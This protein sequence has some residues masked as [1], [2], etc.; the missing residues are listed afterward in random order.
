MR[1]EKAQH[2]E[3]G[4]RRGSGDTATVL[5]DPELDASAR[6]RDHH[7]SP[8]SRPGRTRGRRTRNALIATGAAVAIGLTIAAYLLFWFRPTTT[9]DGARSTTI[10]SQGRATITPAKDWF[11]VG[12]HSD[13]VELLSPDRCLKVTL[14]PSPAG[15]PDPGGAGAS[16]PGEVRTEELASHLTIAHRD[17]ADRISAAVGDGRQGI[18]LEV[19]LDEK[20][21]QP[22]HR[23]LASY[24]PALAA[25]IETIRLS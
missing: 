17:S 18:Q 7:G 6:P 20:Q 1:R 23:N 3:T 5:P 2:P 16:R 12:D 24:R 19:T 10:G 21:A 8:T 11:V 15:A 13:V 9:A 25:L 4:I 14:S 22:L